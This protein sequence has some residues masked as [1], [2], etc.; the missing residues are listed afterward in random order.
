M[1][2]GYNFTFEVLSGR[3]CLKS[4]MELSMKGTREVRTLWIASSVSLRNAMM[5]PT[6]TVRANK[7]SEPV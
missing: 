2:K 3:F 5:I 6:I 4:W 7:S 1:S